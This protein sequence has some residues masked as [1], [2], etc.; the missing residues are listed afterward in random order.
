MKRAWIIFD[1][2]GTLIESEQIWRDVRQE[3]VIRHAGRWHDGAQAAMIGMRTGEW[4]R[5]IR[6][7]L[8][9]DLPEDEIVRQ[10]LDG[11]V[12]HLSRHIPV[13][14]G[15]E[16]ALRTLS[17]SCTLG[18]ATSASVPVAQTVLRKT[19]WDAFFTATVSADEVERG[20]PAPD[21]YVRALELLHADASCSAGIEDSANG[22]RSA[23]AAG[24]AVVAVPN[25]EFP[26]DAQSLSLATRVLPD[27]EELDD[28]LIREILAK[29]K[30]T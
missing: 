5:Y 2:D 16:H 13:L 1:L 8:A 17:Q 24:L 28:A 29:K 20:K 30:G 14:P 18:L 27:L 23:H 21:V 4:A 10:V 19:G 11:V 7:D 6:N 26:P 22:I 9:V 3:F 25:R 12:Q 15:A